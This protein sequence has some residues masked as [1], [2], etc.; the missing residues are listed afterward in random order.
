[1]KYVQHYPY[2]KQPFKPHCDLVPT[3]LEYNVRFGLTEQ[4][5]VTLMKIASKVPGI[6]NKELAKN[7]ALMEKLHDRVN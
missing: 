2:F 1:M 6:G 3:D 5:P 4:L 7:I